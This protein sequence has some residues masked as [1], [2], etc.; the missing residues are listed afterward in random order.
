MIATSCRRHALVRASRHRGGSADTQLGSV[1]QVSRATLG[2]DDG[3]SGAGDPTL[4]PRLRCWGSRPTQAHYPSDTDNA[5]G[6]PD[7]DADRLAVR[8]LFELMRDVVADLTP[9]FQII[10]CD[11]ADLPEDWFKDAVR[12]RWR[13][14]VKLIPADWLDPAGR[15]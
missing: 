15:S 12:H 9:N 5:A 1:Q 7:S 6:E 8:Q 14:G 4:W 10:V 11:H 3:S 13:D 2:P